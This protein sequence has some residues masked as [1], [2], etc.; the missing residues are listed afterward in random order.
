M[1]LK[2]INSDSSGNCYILEN[3]DSA[4]L[5]E[6]GV[7][8]MQIKEAINFD[9]L[10]IKLCVLT[11]EHLDHSKSINQVLKHGI[12]VVSSH[13]TFK[14]LNIPVD[15]RKEIKHGQSIKTLSGFKVTAF[16]VEHDASEPLGFIIEHE[17]CGKILFVTDSYILRHSF[18]FQFDH[19][20]IEANYC[21]DILKRVVDSK[22]L[23][24]VNSRRFNS[25]MS[26][27][28]AEITIEKLGTE[29]LNNIVLTHLSDGL[30]D[31]KRF[32]EDMTKKFGVVTTIADKGIQ[33]NLSKK[34]F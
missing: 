16:S 27:Q 7:S 12:P 33:I 14:S 28:A 21:Q 20:V 29:N 13:G 6:C 9:M 30:T 19:I 15:L 22:G 1:I 32:K 18:P 25:H 31:S 11:H 26:F 3:K 10:K 2:V 23:D 4:L 5:I 34:P 24:F 8:I 17:D